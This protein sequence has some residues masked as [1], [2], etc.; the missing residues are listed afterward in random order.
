MYK[1]QT[2]QWHFWSIG[3]HDGY[4]ANYCQVCN[5]ND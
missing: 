5:S 1:K 4:I 2:P 3:D